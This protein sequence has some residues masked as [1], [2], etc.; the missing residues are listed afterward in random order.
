MSFQEANF[1]FLVH[2]VNQV[3]PAGPRG[4]E[5]REQRFFFPCSLRAGWSHLPYCWPGCYFCSWPQASWM[6]QVYISH[7]NERR[8]QTLLIKYS[9]SV[10]HKHKRREQLGNCSWSIHSRGDSLATEGLVRV[11]CVKRCEV[12]SGASC[13]CWKRC[14]WHQLLIASNPSMC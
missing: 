14:F 11:Y 8:D 13:L 2:A 3:S 12:P 1:Y 4:E 7:A 5:R 9:F 10:K 6:L